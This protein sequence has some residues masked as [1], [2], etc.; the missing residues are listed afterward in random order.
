MTPHHPLALA[1]CLL[2]A[3]C[4]T[5]NSYTW[6]WPD[7]TKPCQKSCTP[8]ESMKAVA[9]AAGFCRNVQNHYEFKDSTLDN[10]QVLISWTGALAGS[11]AAPIAKGSAVKAWSGLSGITNGLQDS[12]NRQYSDTVMLARRKSVYDA[13]S[14]NIESIISAPDDNARVRAAIAMA[15]AMACALSSASIDIKLNKAL[16]DAASAATDAANTPAEANKTDLA[17]KPADV[18]TPGAAGTPDAATGK[19]Q[20]KS[21]P[22]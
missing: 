8:E 3:A 10:T 16:L 2:L 22:K 9:D 13:A 4:S 20:D 11:V 5:V 1:S 14:K 17:D 6:P 12:L 18:N 19:P 15:M 21:P 7:N